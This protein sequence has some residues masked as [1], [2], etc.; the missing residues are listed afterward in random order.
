[1]THTEMP[2]GIVTFAEGL[3]GFETC[4]A[5]GLVSSPESAPFAVLQSTESGGPS[6]VV[7]DP[8][9]VTRHY[10]PV[11]DEADVTRLEAGGRE[12]L[13]WLAIVM[14]HPDGSATANLRAPIVINPAS[15][16]GIQVVAADSPHRIEH[17][18]QAA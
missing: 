7:V 13:L 3:P 2:D 15:M 4:R 14:V 9:A 11:L 6:F 18:L 5:F 12:P 17:P 1:M 10:R 16:R 8:R